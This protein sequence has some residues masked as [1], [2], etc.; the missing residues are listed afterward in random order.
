ML[1]LTNDRW[2]LSSILDDTKHFFESK[3]QSD[4]TIRIELINAVLKRF[5]DDGEKEKNNEAY[6]SVFK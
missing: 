1:Y 4:K 5:L 3:S 2:L 6:S